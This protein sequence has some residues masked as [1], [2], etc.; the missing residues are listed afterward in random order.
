MNGLSPTKIAKNLA[1]L[2]STVGSRG[3]TF[4][5]KDGTSGQ[6]RTQDWGKMSQEAT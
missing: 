5:R 6:T 1:K 3:Q 2:S 4:M